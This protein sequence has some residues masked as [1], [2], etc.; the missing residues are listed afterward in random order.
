MS[1][2]KEY[3]SYVWKSLPLSEKQRARDIY[4]ELVK[5]NGGVV[6]DIRELGASW[7]FPP[8]HKEIF[9]ILKKTRKSDIIIN[10][11]DELNFKERKML[12][13]VEKKFSERW[14]TK[15]Q[16]KV[17]MNLYK[18]SQKINGSDINV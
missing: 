9:K 12:D 13:K 16:Y 10:S 6:T 11:L 17:I 7:E 15:A 3:K 18:K 1:K 14:K 8:D 4:I 2:V 5:N